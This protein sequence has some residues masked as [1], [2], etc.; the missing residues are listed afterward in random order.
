MGNLNPIGEVWK[1]FA[2]AQNLPALHTAISTACLEYPLLYKA[3]HSTL[4][5]TKGSKRKE[6]ESMFCFEKK[7]FVFSKQIC[8][9][10]SIKN[11]DIQSFLS[12]HVS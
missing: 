6:E 10:F 2:G 3:C 5:P 9:I 1:Q 8:N 7:P 4:M 11:K 12:K